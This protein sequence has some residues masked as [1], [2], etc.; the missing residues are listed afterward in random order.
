MLTDAGYGNNTSFLQELEKKGLKYI[1]GVAKNR[2]VIFK[3]G[4]DE[5]E[6]NRLDNLAKSLPQEAFSEVKLQLEKTKTV[7]VAT[8]EIELSKYAGKKVIAIVMNA[9]T[10]DQ[11]S[12]IP[13]LRNSICLG[14]RSKLKT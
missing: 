10:F 4:E 13:L 5:T 2:K 8:K 6:E 9:A 1:G 14:L 7:W 3:K 11:A 12:D